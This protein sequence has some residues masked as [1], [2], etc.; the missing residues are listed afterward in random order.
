MAVTDIVFDP[1]E[2]GLFE[3]PIIGSTYTLSGQIV[4]AGSTPVSGAVVKAF[5]T[6]NDKFVAQAT[7]NSTGYYTITTPY[8][9]NH[10]IVAYLDTTTD[11][12]GT[13]VNNLMPTP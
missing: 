6:S 13:T 4:D 7:S 11:L 8:F 10:Y 3:L 12:A 1:T 9:V 5:V 2:A